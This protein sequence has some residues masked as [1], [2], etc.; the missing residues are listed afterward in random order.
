MLMTVGTTMFLF[1]GL[2]CI[3]TAQDSQ[4][5]SQTQVATTLSQQTIMFISVGM[6]L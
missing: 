5:A 1:I 2:G 3:K 4:S 6:G